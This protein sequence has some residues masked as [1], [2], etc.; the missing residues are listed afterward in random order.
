MYTYI[1]VRK[2]QKGQ[3]KRNN[4]HIACKNK[5]AYNTVSL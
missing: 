1:F 2:R 4:V 5:V 3:M